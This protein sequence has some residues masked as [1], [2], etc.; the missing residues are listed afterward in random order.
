MT[1]F[2]SSA[3]NTSAFNSE[4]VEFSPVELD[5]EIVASFKNLVSYVVLQEPIL[6]L[7]NDVQLR[8]SCA[9]ESVCDV[10][11]SVV[12]ES[13]ASNVLSLEQFVNNVS[14][15]KF[16]IKNG[17]NMILTI[18]GKEIPHNVIASNIVITMEEGNSNLCEFTVIPTLPVEFIDSVWGKEV[19]IDYYTEDSI[20]RMYTGIIDSP[21]INILDQKV[22]LTCSNRREELIRNTLAEVVKTTGEFSEDVFGKPKDIVEEMN[23]RLE[24]IPVSLDF[25]T[26]NQPSFTEWKSKDTPDYSYDASN[27]YR[28]NPSLAWQSRTKIINNVNITASYQYTRLHHHQRGFSWRAPFAD[29]LC[30][31]LN[32]QYSLLN[33]QMVR[34]AINGAGWRLNGTILYESLW[35]PGV[36]ADGATLLVWQSIFQRGTYTTI[37]DDAGNVVSDPDG[38]NI[39]NFDGF[40]STDDLSEVYTLAASW[41]ATTRFSQ[42]VKEVYPITVTAPQS[43]SQFGY[44]DSDESTDIETDFDDTQWELYKKDT[45]QPVN[46]VSVGAGYYVDQSTERG[47]FFNVQRVMIDRAKTQILSAHRDTQLSLEMAVKPELQLK[48]T[49][50]YDSA[51]ITAKGKV[52]KIVNTLDVLD[53]KDCVSEV[54]IALSRSRGTATTT[55]TTPT[56]IVQDSVSVPTQDVVLPSQYGIEP[57]EAT[58]GYIGNKNNP[59]VAG[60]PFRTDIRE[61]FR[62]DT[63]AIPDSMRKLRELKAGEVI[64]NVEIPNDLLEVVFDE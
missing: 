8:I 21:E 19:T 13:V 60:V 31:F 57:T 47:R 43:V 7:E 62:V 58:T 5:A 37:F 55:P 64:Y 15:D 23:Y 2:N 41:D 34:D 1:T 29:S 59:R 20:Q 54:T 18:D 28:R 36:C 56:P 17:W 26:R 50:R 33:V 46:A 51:K 53:G 35:P 16:L 42:F 4:S 63:P 3:F 10:E 48:H 38:N 11:S 39:Y 22:K 32:N 25:D 44:V 27:I 61:E 12:F 14:S 49:V 40:R 45:A 24:T 6:N 52:V 30:D 9:A